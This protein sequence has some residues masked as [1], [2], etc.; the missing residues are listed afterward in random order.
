[1][2]S[3]VKH[4]KKFEPGDLVE[5]RENVEIERVWCE[6]EYDTSDYP[7]LAMVL[8]EDSQQWLHVLRAGEDAQGWVP[9]NYKKDKGAI[10][11]VE[12]L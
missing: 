5:I 3:N 10:T 12:R 2:K 1:M 8:G 7:V 4:W 9:R 6:D 11:L